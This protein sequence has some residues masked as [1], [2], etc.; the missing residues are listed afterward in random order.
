MSSRALVIAHRGACGHLPEHTIAAYE[1]AIDQGADAIEL[2]VIPAS[3]G[4]LIVRHENE[5]SLTT[6]VESHLDFAARRKIKT[7][8][9]S[10]FDGWFAE[11]FT[12][13]ELS[14]LRSRQRLGF[15]DQSFNGRFPIPTLSQ[16]L[17]WG[18]GRRAKSG[19][20]LRVL[21][22][23]K[24]P[25]YFASI[26]LPFEPPLLAVLAEAPCVPVSVQSFEVA[27]LKKLSARTTIDLIQLLDG[28]S[29]RPWDF[30]I[31]GDPR[32]FA[33]L[34]TPEGLRE[35]KTYVK[36][37]GP[38]KRLIVPARIAS[39]PEAPVRLAAPTSLLDD[40]HTA[41]LGVY[42]WTFRSEP[43]L[44]ASDYVGDP[45]REYEQFKR[46]GLDGVITDFP[47]AAV[48]AYA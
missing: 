9:G 46:L 41:G 35:L 42:A 24:H 32:T 39:V 4:T 36:G 18:R 10:R 43:H 30:K 5:L 48:G 19:R 16:V 47:D 22:E 26:G 12:P 17:D 2:D 1:L 34:L 45:R 11:E 6:D 8:D 25:T 21:V 23:L 40:A 37:I 28:P 7:I 29:Y 38:W 13:E 14:R 15:R 20:P 3:D 27:I 31:A 44:L 33:D